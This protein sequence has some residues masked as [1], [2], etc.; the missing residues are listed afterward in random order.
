MGKSAK[1]VKRPTK[2]QKDNKK[3]AK[4]QTLA[5]ERLSSIARTS[6]GGVNKAKSIRKKAK[7]AS[8]ATRASKSKKADYMDL[9]G[10]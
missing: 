7:A 5:D 6:N 2:K 9:F 10:K 4:A 8:T 1:A 3:T